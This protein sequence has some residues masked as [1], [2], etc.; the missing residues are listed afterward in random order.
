MTFPVVYTAA[1]NEIGTV[2]TYAQLLTMPLWGGGG[3]QE[4]EE[5]IPRHLPLPTGPYAVGYQVSN[6]GLST[7]RI[8]RSI[9]LVQ[10]HDKD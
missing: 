3:G 7:L 5:K 4:K 8:F 9:I 6:W 2:P 1:S 10:D